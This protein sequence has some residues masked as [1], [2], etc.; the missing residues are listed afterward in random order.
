M[1]RQDKSPTRHL[2]ADVIEAS[3]T[4]RGSLD[5]TDW[6]ADAGVCCRLDR[7][8]DWDCTVSTR[9]KERRISQKRKLGG[10]VCECVCTAAHEGHTV[11]EKEMKKSV[12]VA[13]KVLL[14]VPGGITTAT[15]APKTTLRH[16]HTSKRQRL[17]LLHTHTHKD[18]T[19]CELKRRPYTEISR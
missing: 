10:G 8:T 11:R 3:S 5:T 9:A 12:L 1:N 16:I 4:S 6:N 7:L 17:A 14:Y 13:F 15:S 2:L 19:Y 18:T